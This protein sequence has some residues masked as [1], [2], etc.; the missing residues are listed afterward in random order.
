VPGRTYPVL[1]LDAA[2]RLGAVTDVRIL[3]P[4]ETPPTVCLSE[5]GTARVRL[6]D[7]IGRP[8]V[9]HRPVVRVWLPD[10]TPSEDSNASKTGPRQD[11]IFASWFDTVN[12]LS[13]PLTDADGSAVLPALV[14]GLEYRV[15]FVIDGRSVSRS[16]PFRVAPGQTVRL[17]DAVINEDGNGGHTGGLP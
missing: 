7:A 14:P 13:G 4:G 17:P 1:L 6:V 3:G 10:D 12:Y 9:G 2:R 8:L 5:C 15:D 16:S 11:P